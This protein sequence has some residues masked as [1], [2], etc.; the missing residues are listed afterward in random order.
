MF[1]SGNRTSF[2]SWWKEILVKSQKVSKYKLIVDELDDNLIE[3][4][5]EECSYT[6]KPKLMVSKETILCRKVR[7]I[8]RYHAANKLISSQKFAHRFTFTLSVQR[9]KG[10]AIRFYTIISKQT[11]RAWSPG[12]CKHKQNKFW[13][14]WWFSWWVLF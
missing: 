2:Q 4:N 1:I 3:N 11:S 13:T 8:L 14:M 12:C 6:K 9:W 5:H 10:I 7:R